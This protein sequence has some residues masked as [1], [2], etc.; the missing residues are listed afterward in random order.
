MASYKKQVAGGPLMAVDALGR[1]TPDTRSG[2]PAVKENRLVGL[3]YFLWL[4]EHGRHKPYDISKIVAQDPD[5]GHK[6]ASPLWGG[7]GVYHH[8]GEPFYG[9]YYSNDEW[10][11]RKHMKLI[12]QA[13]VDFLFFDTT[14]A[15]IYRDNAKLVMR[16]LQEYHDEGWKIPKVMLY[17]NTASGLTV[18]NI[19][20]SIYKV[21]YC[22]DT[23]FCMDGKPVIIAVEEECTPECR[24]FFNIKMSQWPNEPDKL[25]GW[26]WMDFTRPQRIFANL[27]GVD[28]VIN[29]SVAQHS[30]NI[31]F[32]DSVLYGE[33]SNCGRAYHNGQNDPDPDAWKHGYNFAEQFDRAIET[34]PPIV[35]VTGWNEWIAGYW[36]GIP[37][38]PVMFVDA[39]NY[40]YS[41]DIEMMRGGYFDNY[42]M[43]LVSYVRKYKGTDATPVYPAVKSVDVEWRR[44]FTDSPAVYDCFLD[45]DMHRHAEGQGGMIYANFTQRNV[46]DKIGVMHDKDSIAFTIRTKDLIS[47][48]LGAGSWMKIFLNVEG[49]QSYQYVLNHHTR[50]DGTTTLGKIVGEGDDLKCVDVPDLLLNYEVRGDVMRISVPR[51]VIGLDHDNFTLWFKVADSREKYRSIEDFYDKGDVA[52]LGRLNFVYHGE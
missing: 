49:G 48:P 2:A 27:D 40:E 51:K 20:Y 33:T 26:P 14:N 45:G 39:A 52:P 35:L 47:D 25:G 7:H 5:I 23:W 13:D 16:V 8:W 44:S 30:G 4:G 46:M 22:K 19:Y 15:A 18:L 11:V 24:E 32:G 10:V 36:S 29:V 38:R 37:E 50:K 3:F 12:M 31:R 17:T 1:P 9:Y 28:E 34:D 43:Q 42:F 6:P 41:R 21:G